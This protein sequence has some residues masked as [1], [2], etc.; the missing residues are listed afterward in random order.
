MSQKPKLKKVRVKHIPRKGDKI[1]ITKNVGKKKID[2]LEVENI[3]KWKVSPSYRDKFA[4]EQEIL[5]ISM[6]DD[7]AMSVMENIEMENHL[8]FTY[9]ETEDDMYY[10]I[11]KTVREIYRKDMK[12][13]VKNED[14]QIWCFLKHMLSKI[15]RKTEV[16]FKLLDQGKH[17]EAKAEFKEAKDLFML[18]HYINRFGGKK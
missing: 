1:R 8:V 3:K 5:D 4:K 13:L 2:K 15:K 11:L 16:G 7:L 14:P 6:D 10:E 17:E 12:K 9:A 18:F